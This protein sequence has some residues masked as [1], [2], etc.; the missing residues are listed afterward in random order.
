M[1]K[2]FLNI[3]P[4]NLCTC[5]LQDTHVSYTPGILPLCTA[6]KVIFQLTTFNCDRQTEID[7]L[8]LV[9]S[10]F[11]SSDSYWISDSGAFS[12]TTEY[13]LASIRVKV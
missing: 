8:R 9:C 3:A 13:S 7:L 11:S 10:T 2:N 6:N 12:T 1:L 4:E 5:A